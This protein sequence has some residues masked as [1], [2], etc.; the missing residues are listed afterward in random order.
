M[1]PRG[2]GGIYHC[3]C[4]Q[5]SQVIPGRSIKNFRTSNSVCGMIAFG[6]YHFL[7][8]WL[9]V[10][11]CVCVCCYD[12]NDY[13]STRLICWNLTLKGVALG[14][15]TLGYEQVIGVEPHDQDPG[16]LCVFSTQEDTVYKPGAR[17]SPD[18]S[19]R[20][21]SWTPNLCMSC[22]WST[23]SEREGDQGS[24]EKGGN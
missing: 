6:G 14:R 2:S 13:V 15:G 19:A 9:S 16:R 1:L 4:P 3:T 10:G 12:L 8:F 7:T 22:V 24:G 11:D 21:W 20:P 23:W 5:H 18:T 17:L